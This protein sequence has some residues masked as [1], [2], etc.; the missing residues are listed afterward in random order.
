MR[1]T[2]SVGWLDEDHLAF[3]LPDTGSEGASR[4]LRRLSTGTAL[5][6]AADDYWVINYP[7]SATVSDAV[8]DYERFPR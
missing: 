7:G 4:L 1:A 8:V 6:Q 2:D 3:V 5:A